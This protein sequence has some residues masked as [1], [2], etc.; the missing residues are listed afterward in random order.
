M[1]T[2]QARA[3]FGV[4]VDALGLLEELV[5]AR[6]GH[7]IELQAP[8]SI[9]KTWPLRRARYTAY[10]G[11]HGDVTYGRRGQHQARAKDYLVHVAAV[12]TLDQP[13]LVPVEMVQQVPGG[14]GGDLE[15][16]VD[17]LD[18]TDLGLWANS[19]DLVLEAAGGSRG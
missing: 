16:V 19:S 18:R 4:G 15:D 12:V 1:A 3:A 9:P 17:L 10:F 14:L 13:L 6:I 11:R 7:T 5:G 8:I 2:H